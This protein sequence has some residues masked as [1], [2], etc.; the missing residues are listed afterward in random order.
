MLL[1]MYL[2]CV[3]KKKLISAVRSG[4]GAFAAP[5]GLHLAP[6]K[7]LIVV[8]HRFSHE[9]EGLASLTYMFPQDGLMLFMMEAGCIV[10][11]I[12][13]CHLIHIIIKFFRCIR[14]CATQWTAFV[15]GCLTND[16]GSLLCCSIR[17]I[18]RFRGNCV[19]LPKT[20]SGK[21]MRRVLRKIATK[22]E[23]ELGDLSTLADPEVVKVLLGKYLTM[24]A[25][26]CWTRQT[27]SR[28]A[29]K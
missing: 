25:F 3:Q 15:V 13:Q 12:K 22:D 9:F 6:G 8:A 23:K 5:D 20:R 21:I 10:E 4:V 1:S 11:M 18:L 27:H 26:Q 28:V 7:W 16:N 14:D 19:G 24:Q 29:A 2:A 17:N